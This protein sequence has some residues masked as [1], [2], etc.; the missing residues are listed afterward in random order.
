LLALPEFVTAK[1]IQDRYSATLS[2]DTEKT[3]PNMCKQPADIVT[4]D[5][6]GRVGSGLGLDL[7]FMALVLAALEFQQCRIFDSGNWHLNNLFSLILL[8]KLAE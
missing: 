3:R 5:K 8:H 4:S 6:P 7:D 2:S 1:P